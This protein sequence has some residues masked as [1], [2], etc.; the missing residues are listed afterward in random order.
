MAFIPIPDGSTLIIEYGDGIQNWTNTLTFTK[1]LFDE[2]DQLAL[3][4]NVRDTLESFI[5][6][7]IDVN[8]SLRRIWSYDMRTVT[9]P[10]I[11]AAG[12]PIAGTRPGT[13]APLTIACVASI[14]TAARGRSGR[15]RNYVTGFVEDDTGSERIT[16]AG[17]VAG[18]QNC[19]SVMQPNV[20]SVGWEFVIAQKQQAGVP[21][22]V[23]I[24]RPVTNA[25][26]RSDIFGTQRRRVQRP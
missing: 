9:G 17:L 14:Y 10:I 5:I 12:L 1:P 11:A 23:A 16:S 15:G 18:V 3:A 2:A 6:P 20:G 21:L 26:V 19:Y 4:N 7:W 22:A 8:W 24:T 13:K 25:L